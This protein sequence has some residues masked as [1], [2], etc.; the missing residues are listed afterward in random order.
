VGSKFAYL[1]NNISLGVSG[2]G[3]GKPH[4]E[5]APLDMDQGWEVPPGYPEGMKPM[6][7]S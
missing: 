3:K 5:F 1:K 4:V 7:S 2:M 6:P